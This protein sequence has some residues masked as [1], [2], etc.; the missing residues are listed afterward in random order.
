[1]LELEHYLMNM[2]DVDDVRVYNKNNLK[3]QTIF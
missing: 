2:L 1:M 3:L